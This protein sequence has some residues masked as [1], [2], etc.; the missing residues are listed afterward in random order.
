MGLFTKIIE[1]GQIAVTINAIKKFRRNAIVTDIS[2]KFFKKILQTK[3][4]KAMQLI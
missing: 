2:K 3:A 4:G 1:G